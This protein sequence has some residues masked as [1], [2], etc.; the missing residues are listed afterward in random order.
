MMIHMKIGDISSL[1]ACTA[2]ESGTICK[3]L[4]SREIHFA[5]LITAKKAL[6]G[7]CFVEVV[8]LA[9]WNIWKQR[10]YYIFKHIRPTFRG[11]KAGFF[12]DITMLMHRV[13][14]A[15][16]DSLLIWLKSLH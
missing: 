1:T 12:H 11:W 16:V 8:V 7:P 5:S 13:K 9:C 3:F 14:D 15:D 6:Q 4:G 10:N 2:H